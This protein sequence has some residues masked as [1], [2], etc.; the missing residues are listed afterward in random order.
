ML[1]T[2]SDHCPDPLYRELLLLHS[3]WLL[4]GLGVGKC[5]SGASSSRETKTR[6]RR[7][8]SQFLNVS[9]QV[10][11][12]KKYH[13]G[14]TKSIWG[15]HRSA[16]GLFAPSASGGVNQGPNNGEPGCSGVPGWSLWWSL[17][18]AFWEWEDGTA[19]ELGRVCRLRTVTSARELVWWE[20][21]QGSR[22]AG[23]SGHWESQN[24]LHHCLL[25]Y[26]YCYDQEDHR[27]GLVSCRNVVEL[28]K[29][30]FLLPTLGSPQGC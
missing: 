1:A 12:L 24:R 13:T 25:S 15:L 22:S 9:N 5:L 10:C 21:G 28:S 7:E 18:W 16:G 17:L 27:G 20:D 26:D 30:Y 23:G 4:I 14:Q 11:F 2:V 19:Q 3:N 8:T 29:H 6:C